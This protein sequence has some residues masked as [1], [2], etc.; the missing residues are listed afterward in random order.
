[1]VTRIVAAFAL[2]AGLL[3]GAAAPSTPATTEPVYS[4][5]GWK[6]LTSHRIYSIAPD[7]YTIVF[8]SEQA[9]TK[10]T[11][12]L[13]GPA[14]QIT[15]ITGVPV[16]VSFIVDT[17][18]ATSCPSRHRIVVHYIHQPLGLPGYSQAR[19]CYSTVDN[20]AWGGHLLMD[21]EYWEVPNWFGPDPAVNEMM[22]KNAVTH[23]LGHIFGLDHPNTDLDKDGVVEAYECVK[24][25]AGV[26]PNL[27]SPN[28]GYKTTA[29]AGKYVTEFD[30][31]GLQQ[32]AQNYYLRLN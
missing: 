15:T 32:M 26:K 5:T 9:R 2:A 30:A 12:Y 19:P 20:S 16:T 18:P 29:G 8:A 21:S 11:P 17:T 4:G 24:N 10:L 23:E 3:F 31:K 6:A 14:G 28:G 13:T 22:R 27:C 25:A 7:P 1:M